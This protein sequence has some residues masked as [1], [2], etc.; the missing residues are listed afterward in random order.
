[1]GGHRRE[2][3]GAEGQW[4]P[5]RA[6]AQRI[7]GRVVAAGQHRA[8]RSR[9]AREQ[10]DPG[11]R[12]A[13][14]V[15]G[16]RQPGHQVVQVPCPFGV[17]RHQ[18]RLDR[19]ELDRRGQDHTGQAHAAGGRVEQGRAAAH[20]ADLPVGGEEFEGQ[21]VPGEAT[22]DVVVL[23][24]DVGADRPADRD[25]ARAGRHRHEPA[26]RQQYPH[27]P[28]QGDAR[29]A[30]HDAGGGVDHV[31]AVQGRHVE[32][33]PAGVLRGVPV[34]P[35]QAPG[36]ASAGPAAPD[37]GRGL[38]VAPWADQAGRGGCRAAPSRDGNGLGRHAGDRIVLK[39]AIDSQTFRD[40]HPLPEMGD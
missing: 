1:M 18:R 21:D 7:Q 5:P 30:Q 25:I 31:D 33:R 38:L 2:P 26:Q 10:V 24:V 13:V 9:T 15:V 32:H 20:R 3:G 4:L 28:V 35:S 8:P 11:D 22:A 19:L 6:R 39:W 14:P 16:G 17:H 36:D 40:I 27:Q 23:A 29:V 37:G 12:V 34:S